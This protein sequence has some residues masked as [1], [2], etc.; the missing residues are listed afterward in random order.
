MYMIIWND[1][2]L[3]RLIFLLHKHSLLNVVCHASR[4]TELSSHLYYTKSYYTH[5]L[6]I[7]RCNKRV[8]HLIV[9]EH[10]Y[11]KTSNISHS[12]VDNKW[13]ITQM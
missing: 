12:L 6:L 5:R 11:H 1:F 2:L 9:S 3:N 8:I 13:L 4:D 10:N 7:H